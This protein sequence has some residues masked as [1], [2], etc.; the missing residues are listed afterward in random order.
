LST[1]F[2]G[3]VSQRNVSHVLFG[4]AL[5]QTDSLAWQPLVFSDDVLKII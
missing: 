4:K 1:P 2:E 5:E 3:M